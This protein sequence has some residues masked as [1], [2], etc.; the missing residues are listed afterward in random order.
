MSE[1]TH[2]SCPI[3]LVDDEAQSLTSLPQAT[4]PS[5]EL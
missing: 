4:E 3:L 1:T 2:P 5:P